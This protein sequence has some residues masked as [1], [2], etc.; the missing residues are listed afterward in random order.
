VL[1]SPVTIHE[2]ACVAAGSVLT[3]DVDSTNLAIARERESEIEG[4]V[5]RT[6]KNAEDKQPC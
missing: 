4:W 5:T 1:V 3:K 2:N 6:Q